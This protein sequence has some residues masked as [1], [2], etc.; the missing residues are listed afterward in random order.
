MAARRAQMSA[1]FETSTYGTLGFD[2]ASSNVTTVDLGSTVLSS[3]TDCHARSS[4]IMQSAAAALGLAALLA[5][6]TGAFARAR[7]VLV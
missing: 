2:H 6:R 3:S 7:A 1:A 4:E 5:V